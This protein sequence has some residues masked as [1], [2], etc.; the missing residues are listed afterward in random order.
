VR[1]DE[2]FYLSND[3]SLSWFDTAANYA[4]WVDGVTGYEQFPVNDRAYDPLYDTWYWSADRVDQGLYLE[5]AKLAG[6]AGI[7][8]FLADSGWDAPTGEYD[9]WLAGRTGDYNPP[10]GQFPDLA[11]TLNS[12]RNEYGLNV[13]LWLQPFAVGRA[14]SRYPRTRFQHIHVPW[15]NTFPGW[16]GLTHAPFALP[17]RQDLETVNLCPRVTGTHAYLRS[18]FAEVSAK[19]TPD[20]YWI[21]F[22]DGLSSYCSAPHKHN[23]GLFGD[24]LNQALQAMKTAILEANPNAVVRFRAPY[25]NLN[26]KRYASVWQSQDSPGDFDRMRMNA[27]RLRPF[28]NGVV[29]ASD[30]TYWKEI[31][32]PATASK[33]IITSLMVGVPAFGP[34]LIR[35][36]PDVQRLLRAWVEF[37]KEN[38]ID[39]VNGRFVPFGQLAMPNH[40]IEGETST[41]VYVRNNFPELIAEGQTIFIMNVTN[42]NQVV[43]RLRG[44]AGVG[45]YSVTVMNRFLG[46]EQ[47]PIV[48]G[49]DRSGIVNL[50]VSVEQGGMIHLTPLEIPDPTPSPDDGNPVETDLPTQL[51]SAP[52]ESLTP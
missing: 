3:N 28:S 34:D 30:Q 19:Y 26:T 11:G 22:L 37:Y 8:T 21:D 50:N 38:R 6:E 47:G 1:F 5:T 4:D 40:K 44:P 13:E 32:D 41:F 15:Q 51:K 24:G 14:S 49:A 23:V 43:T 48:V 42:G 12:I 36:T 52:V 33:F 20:G 39:L 27:L 10:P 31:T 46:V 16:T 18:L 25:A 35:M 45:I 29:F 9:K 7:P 17:I 2:V